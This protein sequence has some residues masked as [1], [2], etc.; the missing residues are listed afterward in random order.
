M[1]GSDCRVTEPREASRR[2]MSRAVFSAGAV[3]VGSLVA[4]TRRAGY[5]K[6]STSLGRTSP[7]AVVGGPRIDHKRCL[8][9]LVQTYYPC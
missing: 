5:I 1:G 4:I 7:S 8:F 2:W 9:Q 6:A 3:R